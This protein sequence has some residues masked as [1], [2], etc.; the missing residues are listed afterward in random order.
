MDFPGILPVIRPAA[1][2][3][4]VSLA[5]AMVV[6]GLLKMLGYSDSDLGQ[7][8]QAHNDRMLGGAAWVFLTVS[9]AQVINYYTGLY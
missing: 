4:G 8:A 1:V 2:I 5:E 7:V 3:A 6:P 9:S